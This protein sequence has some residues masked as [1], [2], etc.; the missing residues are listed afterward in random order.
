MPHTKNAPSPNSNKRR[1]PK[2]T[3]ANLRPLSSIVSRRLTRSFDFEAQTEFEVFDFLLAEFAFVLQILTSIFTFAFK[4]FAQRLQFALVG[5]T[6][7]V[8]LAFEFL[9]LT[10]QDLCE[11]EECALVILRFL[12][13]GGVFLQNP[14]R[15]PGE[16]KPAN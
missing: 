3:P 13:A 11:R 16:A 9:I 7:G 6:V 14:A 15:I 4:A 12:D 2:K 5:F 10:E 8:L 1:R